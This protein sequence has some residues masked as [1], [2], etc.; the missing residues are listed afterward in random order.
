VR[1]SPPLNIITEN[2]VKIRP[3]KLNVL[4]EKRENERKKKHE[5]SHL[6]FKG[7]RKLLVIP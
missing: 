1:F 5:N 6:L 2:E 7:T 3:A 4:E